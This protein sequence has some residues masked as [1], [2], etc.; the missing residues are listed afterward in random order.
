MAMQ[1]N[2]TFRKLA[3]VV[4]FVLSTSLILLYQSSFPL[5]SHTVPQYVAS[6]TH[7]P[8]QNVSRDYS[9]KPIVYI[10][11]QYYVFEDNNRLHGENF[12][13]WVNV[14]KVTKN[15]F[16]LETIRPH[17]SIGF[18]NGLEYA[19][20][21]RQGDFLRNSGFYGAVFHHYWFSGRPVMEH[22]I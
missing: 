13:E 1:F 3:V 12:T 2:A 8:E 7:K 5:H 21:K 14:K 15:A 18:Y 19:T 6:G 17:E 10:F 20:R 9:I 22:I 11:P 4:T 16:G